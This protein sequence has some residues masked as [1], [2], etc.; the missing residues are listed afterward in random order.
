M[1]QLK[2]C[3]FIAVICKTISWIAKLILST[4]FI[5]VMPTASFGQNCDG[6]EL[7]A[8]ISNTCME[9][10]TGSI[11]MT[12]KNGSGNYNFKW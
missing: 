11:E 5:V 2:Y 12:I 3:S 6:F 4:L 10:P 7:A 8:L 9:R 1:Y